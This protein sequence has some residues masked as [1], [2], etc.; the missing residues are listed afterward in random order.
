MKL[1]DCF[2][3]LGQSKVHIWN[4]K[5]FL[6]S[7]VARDTKGLPADANLG[8]GAVEWSFARTQKLNKRWVLEL[9]IWHPSTGES[10]VETLVWS[11][12]EVE[13]GQIKKL[14]EKTLQKRKRI[15]PKVAA[16]QKPAQVKYKSDKIYPYGL[17]ATKSG[18]RWRVGREKG[19]LK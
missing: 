11:V 17:K 1:K 18:V 13:P 7:L 5:I 12:Y 14:L 2:F 6:N 10:E 15:E 3:T 16:G 9:G 19:V 8:A 4:D